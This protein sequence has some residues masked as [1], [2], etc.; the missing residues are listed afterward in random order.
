[1]R[2]DLDLKKLL[3][4]IFVSLILLGSLFAI[5]FVTCFK[6]DNKNLVTDL[7]VSNQNL[8]IKVVKTHIFTIDFSIICGVTRKNHAFIWKVL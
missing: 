6:E 5:I 7:I 8:T 4:V 3:S 2:K 1:M